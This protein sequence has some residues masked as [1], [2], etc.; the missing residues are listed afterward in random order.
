MFSG[1]VVQVREK[2]I[3]SMSA[4]PDPD[5][6]QGL[7]LRLRTQVTLL[8]CKEPMAGLEIYRVLDY[9]HTGVGMDAI[10]HGWHCHTVWGPTDSREA[11]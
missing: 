3:F 1:C 9:C 10:R 8:F 7:L 4:T 2:T 6:P 11:L 5:D